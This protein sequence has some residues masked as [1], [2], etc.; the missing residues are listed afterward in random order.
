MAIRRLDQL[1]SVQGRAGAARRRT[2]G[3]FLLIALLG[4][5]MLL[6]A[7]AA[8]GTPPAGASPAQVLIC[9][10]AV[11]PM[12]RVAAE[13]ATAIP[14]SATVSATASAT[15]ATGTPSAPQRSGLYRP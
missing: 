12:D 13:C 2:G 14:L 15:R 6:A 1:P 11:S 8:A 9:Q 10:T 3:L 4:V 7:R 5:C